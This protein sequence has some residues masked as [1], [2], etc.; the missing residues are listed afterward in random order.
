M[1]YLPY[2]CKV[3]CSQFL[4]PFGLTL[5]N[6]TQWLI[7]SL[8]ATRETPTSKALAGADSSKA[9]THTLHA[10]HNSSAFAGLFGGPPSLDLQSG[11]ETEGDELRVN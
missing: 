3:T 6:H 11:T 10:R 8:Q 5:A 9:P 2:L 4:T 1:A 7:A